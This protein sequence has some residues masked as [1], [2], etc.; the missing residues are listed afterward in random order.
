[1]TTLFLALLRL[2]KAMYRAWED[3]EF[4][5]LIA[6]MIVMAFSGAGFYSRHEGW[7]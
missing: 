3:P 1:M 2:G 6:L 5:A 7:S 4:R